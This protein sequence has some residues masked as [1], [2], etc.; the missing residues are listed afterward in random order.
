MNAREVGASV[1]NEARLRGCSLI[2]FLTSNRLYVAS[3]DWLCENC[4]RPLE[5]RSREFRHR[6]FGSGCSDSAEGGTSEKLSPSK[7][8]ELTSSSPGPSNNSYSLLQNDNVSTREKSL[9]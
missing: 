1:F 7:L 2:T 6:Y 4:Y 8:S 9:D 3:K 5:T